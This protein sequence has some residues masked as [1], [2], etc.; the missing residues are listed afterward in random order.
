MEGDY[1]LVF[2][3]ELDDELFLDVLR[4]VGTL[5]LVEELTALEIF[6]PF[7]PR[8]L[9]VV[10]T[11]ECICYHFE[12]LGLLAYT[13]N[14]TGLHAVRGNVDNLAVYNDVL[15]V[16]ELTGSSTGGSNAETVND[17]VETAFKA[18]EKDFTGNATGSGSLVEENAELLLKYTIGIL[19]LLLLSEH[20]TILRGLA[21]AIVTVLAGREVTLS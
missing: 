9:A 15:V 21:A 2:R 1:G 20:D 4:N 12:R 6:V 3:V 10:E 17:V 19:G 18:L 13:D 11:G 5:R 7:N 16:N 8:I 14:L